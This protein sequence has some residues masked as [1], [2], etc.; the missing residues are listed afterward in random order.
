LLP[1]EAAVS[2]GDTL[3]FRAVP[4]DSNGVIVPRTRA[5]WSSS[6][7][8][9]ATID[10]LGLVQARA[11]GETAIR[12]Q[13]A[14][15]VAVGIL[16]VH[17]LA[18]RRFVRAAAGAEH[19]CGMAGSGRVYCWGGN[20]FGQLGSGSTAASVSAVPVQGEL[21][22]TSLAAGNR[23][24]CAARA[25]SGV[26]CW[27]S[28]SAGQLG[29][30]VAGRKVQPAPV[31]ALIDVPV[32]ALTAGSGHSCALSEQGNAYCWGANGLGQL[33]LGRYDPISGPG[34]VA[35]SFEFVNIT[36][37]HAHTCAVTVS[38][39][40]HCWGWNQ[41]GQLG[42]QDNETCGE[43]GP[44]CHTQPVHVALPGPMRTV[45]AGFGFSCALGQDGAAYCWGLNADGELGTGSLAARAPP[46]LVRGHQFI[47]LAA[48]ARHAC[49]LSAN[50]AVHCWGANL[51]GELGSSTTLRSAEP[52][53]ALLPPLHS[54][55]A[56]AAHTCGITDRGT[57]FCWGD[58]GD[59]RL[60]LAQPLG[61]PAPAGLGMF[62]HR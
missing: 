59:G 58:P 8:D 9:V 51:S 22:A 20:T 16:Q 31:A 28:N 39:E 17:A 36:A 47:A 45:T 46:S 48:G 25:P 18:S 42:V 53:P 34:Q 3:R 55:D 52:I 43:D 6:R 49:G 56:G 27:G 19:T 24:S 37:G 26:W 12:A 60:G 62:R 4:R 57:V 33:G 21:H 14:G 1:N 13:V 54:L 41:F 61:Y 7:P 32:A 50:G 40:V 38:H 2:E 23:H 30:A 11:P 15:I 29:D 10:S 35:G 5:I 44:F